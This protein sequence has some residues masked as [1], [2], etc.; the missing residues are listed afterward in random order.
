MKK[1]RKLNIESNV[2]NRPR[3]LTQ[4]VVEGGEEKVLPVGEQTPY[5]INPGVTRRRAKELYLCYGYTK[6]MLLEDLGI[7]ETTLDHWLY[8]PTDNNLSWKQEKDLFEQTVLQRMKD[9]TAD[10]LTDIAARGFGILKRSL[11]AMDLE[12]K[13]FDSPRQIKEF[14]DA[15]SKVKNLLQL[16]E[17]KPTSIT[18]ST[19][20]TQKEIGELVGE[21]EDLDPFVD[22][23]S[24]GRIN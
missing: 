2:K 12:G 15:V 8:N 23:S 3:N 13:V 1:T 14:T 6:Q 10:E 11:V 4:T 24:K 22:Y 17:G 7:P 16:E 21:L 9:R 18:A 20:L 5:E 19:E